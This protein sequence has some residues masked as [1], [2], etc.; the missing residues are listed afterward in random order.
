MNCRCCRQRVSAHRE[1]LLAEYCDVVCFAA[2]TTLTPHALELW[3]RGIA[4]LSMPSSLARWAG[5]GEL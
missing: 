4:R 2:A 5:R 3:R 1:G